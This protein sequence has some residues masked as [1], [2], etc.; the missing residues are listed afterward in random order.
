MNFLSK[1]PEWLQTCNLIQF[2]PEKTQITDFQAR[3]RYLSKKLKKVQKC[4]T[5]KAYSADVYVSQIEKYAAMSNAPAK[6]YWSM[7]VQG[8]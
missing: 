2:D 6:K 7:T 4:E 8:Q 3:M 1:T 5:K